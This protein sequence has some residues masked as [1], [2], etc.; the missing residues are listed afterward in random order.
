LFRQ[1]DAAGRTAAARKRR[2]FKGRLRGWQPRELS[3]ALG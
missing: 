2:V 3:W 1:V